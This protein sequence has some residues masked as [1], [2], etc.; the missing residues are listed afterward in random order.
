MTEFRPVRTG[1]RQGGEI[2]ILD[3]LRPGERIVTAGAGFVKEGDRV[4]IEVA[5]A[6][7][8]P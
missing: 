3:G 1:S 8:R 4:R 7:P 2:E 5:D 6:E